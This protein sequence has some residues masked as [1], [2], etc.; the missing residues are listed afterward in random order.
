VYLKRE[1]V[2]PELERPKWEERVRVR[3]TVMVMELQRWR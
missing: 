1:P 2:W 3:V